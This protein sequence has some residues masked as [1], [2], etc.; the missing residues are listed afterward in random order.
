MLKE[1]LYKFFVNLFGRNRHCIFS[2]FLFSIFSVVSQQLQYSQ[3]LLLYIF[4]KYQALSECLVFTRYTELMNG[5]IDTIKDA[6]LLRE[7]NIIV[8]HLRSDEEV[9]QLFNGMSKCIRLTH[10]PYI[11]KVI[12]NV[13]K[14][15]RDIPKVR[16][17]EC[18]KM[19]V[20]H[21]WKLLTLFGVL[22][23]M[24]LVAL[25]SFCSIYNCRIFNT[26]SGTDA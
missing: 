14:T 4:S 18:M 3:L 21:S 6:K 17:R 11:D 15:Y 9:A 7:K 13:T 26:V 5:I 24:L 16:V 8:H 19:Y 2:S 1:F 23:L 20:Y 22:C 25:Q 12:E 10:A